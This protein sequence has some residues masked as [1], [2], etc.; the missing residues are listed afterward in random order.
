MAPLLDICYLEAAEEGGRAEG[1]GGLRRL[2]GGA[3]DG[4]FFFGFLMRSEAW[5]PVDLR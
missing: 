1:G 5:S 2:G 3:F 4:S